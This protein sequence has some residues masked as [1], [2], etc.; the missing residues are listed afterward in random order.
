[1]AGN[2]MST[3]MMKGIFEDLA[4]G[5][6]LPKRTGT[7]DA[8]IDGRAGHAASAAGSSNPYRWS[9]H[10]RSTASVKLRTGR[11][12]AT[13]ET[14]QIGLPARRWPSDRTK[15]PEEADVTSGSCSDG[16]R[17]DSCVA[18]RA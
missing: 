7:G 16:D 1:M 11:D 5:H 9:W 13:G 12:P 3:V 2:G 6:Q 4:E 14:M 18:T 10:T 8:L 15:E 17:A